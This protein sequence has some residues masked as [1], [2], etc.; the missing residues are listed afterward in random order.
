MMKSIARSL[1]KHIDEATSGGTHMVIGHNTRD[2]LLVLP[3]PHRI[4]DAFEEGFQE[5]APDRGWPEG[6]PSREVIDEI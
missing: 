2:P 6:E 5:A 3:D 1:C 4:P